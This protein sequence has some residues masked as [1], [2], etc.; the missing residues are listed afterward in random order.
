MSSVLVFINSNNKVYYFFV[1]VEK[2]VPKLASLRVFNAN[3][4]PDS[5]KHIKTL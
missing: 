2:N 5:N 4:L 3:A 1:N